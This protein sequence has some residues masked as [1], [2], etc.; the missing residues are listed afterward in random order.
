MK[1]ISKNSNL[2]IVLRAGLSAQPLTGTPAKPTVSVRFKDGVADVQQ[3]ELIDLM[4]LHPGFNSDF[5]SAE[6][7]SIDPY[8]STRQS[9]E[10]AHVLTEM[11]YGTP[12][13]RKVGGPAEIS[14]ELQK[15]VQS[16]AVEMAKSMLPS[17]VEG[18]LKEILASHEK[19]KIAN[20]GNISKSGKV[21]GKPGRKPK[22]KPVEKLA[23]T[24]GQII[25]E[26]TGN[27]LNQESVS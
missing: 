22:I 11:K 19:N 3:Q 5:I 18:T 9:S 2:L 8:A 16:M 10:P 1:F 13:S 12:V 24:T 20:G 15:M 27:P 17:M 4:L 6:N 25:P 14:P 21:K 7:S 23:E 26:A